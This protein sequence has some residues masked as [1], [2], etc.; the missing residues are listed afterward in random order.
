MTEKHINQRAVGTQKEQLAAR[1]LKAQGMTILAQNFRCRLGEIDIVG[2]HNGY[3]VFVEVKYRSGMTKGYAEEAVD[4]RKQLRI[5][6]VA[7]FYRTRYHLGANTAIR[8]DVVAIQGEAV[9]WIQNAFE[10]RYAGRRL[11]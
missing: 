4:Y 6:G 3:L 2:R 8:Y 1:Y 11:R 9:S 10:H 5:C 7:D